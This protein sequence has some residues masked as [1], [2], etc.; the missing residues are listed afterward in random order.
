MNRRIR[1]VFLLAAVLL[2]LF[3][4]GFAVPAAL[5]QESATPLV[6]P[7]TPM[8]TAVT[9]KGA[10]PDGAADAA[11]SDAG[12]TSAPETA[13]KPR[14]AK[15]TP[16][17]I[18]VPLRIKALE[19]ADENNAVLNE[20]LYALNILRYS[21]YAAYVRPAAGCLRNRPGVSNSGA[22]AGCRYRR[23]ST[24]ADRQYNQYR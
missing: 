19:K 15:R 1:P 24:A 5:A 21:G 9:Q 6:T 4:V 16:R 17:L 18:V 10:P 11:L 3:T 2:C 13:E 7:E 8:P 14:R 20:L 12:E 22:C 23:V